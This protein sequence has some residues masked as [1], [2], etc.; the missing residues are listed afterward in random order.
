[1]KS[2]SKQKI[3]VSN[4]FIF[5]MG[6]VEGKWLMLDKLWYEWRYHFNDKNEEVR[7]RSMVGNYPESVRICA[8]KQKINLRKLGVK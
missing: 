2:F 5:L 6:E 3:S 8:K 1:M 7:K 4:D